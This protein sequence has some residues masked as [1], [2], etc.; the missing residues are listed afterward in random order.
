V[1][2]LVDAGQT[3]PALGTVL[4]TKD[5]RDLAALRLLWSLRPTRPWD[6]CGPAETVYELADEPEYAE[7]LGD[8][9]DLLLRQEDERCR[10]VAD[11]TGDSMGPVEMLF[12]VSGIWLQG[13]RFT[14]PPRVVEVISKSLADELVMGPY[15]FRSHDHLDDLARCM[16]RWF[17]YA[18]HEFL[19]SLPRVQTW[20]SPD[21]EAI[22]RAWG[23]VPCP[24]CQRYLLARAGEVG[25]ALD[26]AKP[27]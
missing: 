13:C 4:D 10:L 17:R 18:F 6:R 25:I 11:G 5:P 16:E 12:R 7:M 19:P 15:H 3:A 8:N 1:C 22:L 24:E 2:N 20:Q 14:E 23:A 9:P 26:E 27:V 21:R